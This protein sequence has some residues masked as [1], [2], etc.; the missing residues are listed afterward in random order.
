MSQSS[1]KI[2]NV[3]SAISFWH[4]HQSLILDHLLLSIVKKW[5]MIGKRNAK[6][7]KFQF[8]IITCWKEFY[9]KKSRFETGNNTAF[10]QTLY[11][12]TMVSLSSTVDDGHWLST[13]RD[14][15]TNGLRTCTRI[16]I[17]MLLN[18]LSLTSWKFY[19][20]PS[21]MDKSC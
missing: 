1:N 21:A 19:K 12:S 7:L 5:S 3:W 8:L 4:L 13:H 17:C 9:P 14:R 15:L 16:S 2:S 20:M 11:Q 10:Q 6:P 18:Y